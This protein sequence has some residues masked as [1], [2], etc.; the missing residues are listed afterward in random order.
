MGLFNLFKGK[1]LTGEEL[2]KR[3][4]EF[5]INWN[6]GKLAPYFDEAVSSV[7]KP[8]DQRALYWGSR[9]IHELLRLPRDTF[10]KRIGEVAEIPA[11]RDRVVLFH[12]DAIRYLE[13]DEEAYAI[14]S[15]NLKALTGREM[16][17]EIKDAKAFNANWKMFAAEVGKYTGSM[18][19]NARNLL[20]KKLFTICG[21]M[22]CC[23]AMNRLADVTVD[24]V[25]NVDRASRMG[26]GIYIASIDL[27]SGAKKQ[28]GTPSVQQAE[29]FCIRMAASLPKE[30]VQQCL[31]GKNEYIDQEDENRHYR[32]LLKE[33]ASKLGLTP[34]KA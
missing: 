27:K 12:L 7:K 31:D 11:A 13:P 34:S 1:R 8:R 25:T 33:A 19:S 3:L 15:S 32:M 17:K 6:D 30:I 14:I 26:S 21:R 2:K 4:I 23:S 28:S 9:T 20:E 18:D 22:N 10:R 29:N 16:E 24:L 5:D